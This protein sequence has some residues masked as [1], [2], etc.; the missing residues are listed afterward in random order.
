MYPCLILDRPIGN[1]QSS[2]LADLRDALDGL[3][4]AHSVENLVQCAACDLRYICGGGCRMR[5]LQERGDMRLTNCSPEFQDALCRELI[6][7]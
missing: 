2:A 5:N 1:I 3:Y 6:K 4:A 7:T